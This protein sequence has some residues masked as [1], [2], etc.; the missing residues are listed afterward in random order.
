MAKPY[1]KTGLRPKKSYQGLK[2][3]PGKKQ[4]QSIKHSKSYYALAID[5]NRSA[6]RG[7]CVCENCGKEI[8]N[9]EGKNVSHIVSK[10][11]NKELYLDPR[12]YFILC[13]DCENIWT[14]RQKTKMAI[15]AESEERRML[16]NLEYYS[17]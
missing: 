4:A 6:N 9:P 15:Y 1:P 17:K 12:N 3:A 10:G 13:F 11:A 8:K 16:L 5:S 7:Q 14:T 2:R